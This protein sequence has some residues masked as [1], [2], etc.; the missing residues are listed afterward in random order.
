M[1]VKFWSSVNCFGNAQKSG[2]LGE[3][4]KSSNSIKSNEIKFSDVLK[5]NLFVPNQICQ[6]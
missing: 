2:I 6:S 3:V 4:A 1:Q 5:K